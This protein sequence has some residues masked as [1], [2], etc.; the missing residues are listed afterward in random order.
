M[1]S[2]V[3]SQKY[4]KQMTIIITLFGYGLIFFFYFGLKSISR[5]MIKPASITGDNPADLNWFAN[6]W[7]IFLCASL[8]S[9]PNRFTNIFKTRLLRN[10][11]KYSYGIYLLH[12]CA[13]HLIAEYMPKYNSELVRIFYTI[14][15]AYWLGK[16]FYFLI[17]LPL[18]KVSNKAC[19][20]V[21]SKFNTE[22]QRKLIG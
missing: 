17:E 7:S 1:P 13:L 21:T 20:Y 16:L 4:L 5:L 11:G 9:S 15:L 10:S 19:L 2:Y 22:N 3:K 12:P 18:L 14:C 6:Y 8:L